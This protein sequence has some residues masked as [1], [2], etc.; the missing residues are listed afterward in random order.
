MLWEMLVLQSRFTS[1]LLLLAIFKNA[2]FF[3]Q[4]QSIFWKKKF[5]DVLR[6]RTISVAFYI[7]FGTFRDFKK[8]Q[9]FFSEKPFFLKKNNPNLERFEEFYYYCKLANYSD[10]WKTHLLF[11]S[12]P[13]VRPFWEILL[14]QSKSRAILLKF[15]EKNS[16]TWTIDVGSFTPAQLAYIG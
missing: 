3:M 4:N 11:L 16:H 6:N 8:T 9:K 5:M 13:K 10:F 15:D 1:N 12:N 7:K 2:R 14:F